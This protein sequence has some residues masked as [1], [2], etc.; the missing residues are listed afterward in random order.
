[1]VGPL[2]SAFGDLLSARSGSVELQLYYKKQMITKVC[3]LKADSSSRSRL[4]MFKNG[5]LPCQ[6]PAV[7]GNFPFTHT[8]D[9]G[10]AYLSKDRKFAWTRELKTLDGQKV[11][12]RVNQGL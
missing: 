10:M 9:T 6:L 1:M 2:E 7:C 5:Y 3:L 4:Y 12:L 8:C 11:N